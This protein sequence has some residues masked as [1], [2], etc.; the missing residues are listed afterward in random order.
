MTYPICLKHSVQKNSDERHTF[1]RNVSNRSPIR[2]TRKRLEVVE[3]NV[4]K[5]PTIRTMRRRLSAVVGY[6]ELLAGKRAKLSPIDRKAV[7]ISKIKARKLEKKRQI[8]IE[9]NRRRAW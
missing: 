8:V 5:Q 6:I 3:L 7:I 2:G 4:R 9:Y 1:E